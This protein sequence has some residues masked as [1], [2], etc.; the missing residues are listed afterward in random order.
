MGTSQSR[1]MT[2]TGEGG[3]RFAASA[4][5]EVTKHHG[6]TKGKFVGSPAL[7]SNR[8]QHHH[9]PAHGS[10]VTSSHIAGD[11][12]GR[13]GKRA[14]TIETGTTMEVPGH[15]TGHKVSLSD[16]R[17]K[18]AEERQANRPRITDHQLDTIRAT[19]NIIKR[20]QR[21]MGMEMFAK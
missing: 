14:K 21:D 10:G 9:R 13:D 16:V 11:V 3:E 5:A 8:K 17:R 4:S 6:T 7:A 12:T 18:M 1:E 15:V 2:E 19:W 20:D